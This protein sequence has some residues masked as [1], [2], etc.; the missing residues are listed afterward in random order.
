MAKEL[1]GNML[2]NSCKVAANSLFWS[3]KVAANS[4]I[5]IV[6]NHKLFV[7]IEVIDLLEFTNGPQS[8]YLPD[9]FC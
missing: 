2:Q 1:H 5:L 3:L 9:I 6:F 4:N 8:P 7:H